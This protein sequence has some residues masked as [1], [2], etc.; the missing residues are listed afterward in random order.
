MIVPFVDLK[1]QY[2]D[3]K[4]AVDTIVDEVFEK[5][6]FIGGSAVTDFE[7]SFQEYIGT[8]KAVSVNSGTDALILGARALGLKP[9][10]EVIF[11]ANTYYATLLAAVV[12]GLSV[13]LS[14]VSADDFGYDLKKLEQRITKKTKAIMLVHLYGQPDK[15]SDVQKMIKRTGR[16]IHLLEDACQAHGARYRGK[17]VGSFGSFSAFSFYPSKN[18]GAYGDGGAITTNDL[19]LAQRMHLLKEYGQTEKYHHISVGFNSRLDTL[20]AAVLR[21]KLQYVDEWNKKRQELARRYNHYLQ[22]VPEI[23]LP[24]TFDERPSVFHLYVI[25][26][27]RRDELQRYLGEKGITTQIHYPYPIHLQQAWS[28]LGYRKGDFPVAE[29]LANEILSLPMYP[30]LTDEQV[31]YVSAAIINFFFKFS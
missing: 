23:I 17:R 14:D 16:Q 28:E 13:I 15:I 12:N 4:K 20:Q 9:G 3:H 25:R 29:T 31:R 2:L 26:T 7:T 18:L 6:I 10:D 8:R 27:Q 30:E 24:T 22:I 21:Y 19:Q 1:K 11:P 5:S